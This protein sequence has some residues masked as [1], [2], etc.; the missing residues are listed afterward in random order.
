MEKKNVRTSVWNDDLFIYF[1]EVPLPPPFAVIN[2]G[3]KK[4]TNNKTTKTILVNNSPLFR[5]RLWSIIK[6]V[7]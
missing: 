1:R 5:S 7:I 4:Q 6:Q 2:D 3:Q